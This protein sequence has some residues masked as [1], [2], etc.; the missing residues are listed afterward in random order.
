MANAAFIVKAAL[1]AVWV[2]RVTVVEG[3]EWVLI[4]VFIKAQSYSHT[5]R[6]AGPPP[7]FD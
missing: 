6:E 4:E 1:A 3:P 2:E 5:D 7:G